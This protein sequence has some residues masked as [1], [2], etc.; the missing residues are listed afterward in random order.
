MT[1]GTAERETCRTSAA[2]GGTPSSD[3]NAGRSEP[4]YRQ[5]MAW[6]KELREAAT[7]RRSRTNRRYGPAHA[8]QPFPGADRHKQVV[9]RPSCRFTSTTSLHSG[10]GPRVFKLARSHL[11]PRR[12]ADCNPSAPARCTR[13]QPSSLIHSLHSGSVTGSPAR[14]G[15]TDHRVWYRLRRPLPTTPPAVSSTA[16][17]IGLPRSSLNSQRSIPPINGQ[18]LA[19]EVRLPEL[20]QNWLCRGPT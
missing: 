9:R 2:G 6:I 10:Q 4:P 16:S 15:M 11:P 8:A 20:D 7:G 19:G 17:A 1:I 14:R 13:Q 3:C 18:R 5:A 12:L